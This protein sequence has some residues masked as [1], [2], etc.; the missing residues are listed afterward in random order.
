M[1]YLT[2]M[3]YF[4]LYWVNIIFQIDI[5]CTVSCSVGDHGDLY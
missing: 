4:L 5:V 2:Y 1:F 3:C